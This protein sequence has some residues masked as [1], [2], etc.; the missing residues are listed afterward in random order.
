MSTGSR[1]LP[2]HRRRGSCISSQNASAF[3]R[4]T[5][6]PRPS[7]SAGHAG[8]TERGYRDP[9]VF[10]PTLRR[11]VPWPAVARLSSIDRSRGSEATG[12]AR[13]IGSL[14][15]R[16]RTVLL[17]AARSRRIERATG[18][19][20]RFLGPISDLCSAARTRVSLYSIVSPFTLNCG[21]RHERAWLGCVHSILSCPRRDTSR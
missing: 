21:R 4:A 19:I 2:R 10:G 12:M 6:S 8:S 17:T 5:C 11:W 13:R 16:G 15:S 7:A 18:G 1:A 14:S 9:A 20:V 3:T